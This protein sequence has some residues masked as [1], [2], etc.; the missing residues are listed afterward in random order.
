MSK[1]LVP[2]LLLLSLPFCSAP[3]QAQQKAGIAPAAAAASSAHQPKGTGIVVPSLKG[4]VFVPEAADV[5]KAGV[6]LTGVDVH[7]IAM[8]NNDDFR[9]LMA[10]YIG[11]PLTLDGL[12]ALT[13]LVVNYYRQQHHP[14]VDVLAPEQSLASGS[15]QIV[16]TEFR[17]GQVRATGNRWFSSSLVTAPMTLHHGDTINDQTVVNDLDAAN[18]NPFRRVNLV[19]QPSAQPG[20]T[21]IVLQTQDRL[22]ISLFS[23]FDNSGTPIT[24]RSRWN[25]GA[26]WGNALW[27]DQQLSWQMSTSDDFYTG[28]S[29]APG[30]PGGATFNGQNLTWS[31]PVFGRDSISLSGNYDRSLPN[32]GQ[33]FGL[34]GQSLGV[35]ARYNH[36][37]HRTGN[38]VQSLQA[39]YDFKS[40]N[41]NLAFGGTQVMR[42]NAEIDQFTTGYSA[43]LTDSR[44]STSLSTSLFFSP[45]NITP[46]NTA[47]AFQPATGQSGRAFASAH[48]TYWRS[49]VDRLTKLPEGAVWSLRVVGQTSSANLLYTEQL[50]GG[51]PEILRGYDPNSILGDQGVIVSNELR[52]PAFKKAG[53]VSLG[54]V[55]LLTFWDWAHLSSVHDVPDAIN[56][57][58]ASSV[59]AGIR[60]NIRTNMAVKF[61]Y[62][63]QLQHLTG[64]DS[65]DH[66]AN[67][68][69]LAS[70]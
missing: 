26:S 36:S 52:T 58:N 59:G 24:G 4:L 18:T 32:V 35:S 46:D 6:A 19:Y 38:L 37:L 60:Y 27:H 67:I 23:G 61:D 51:G 47:Q 1:A 70:Y 54:Q 13:H 44:G 31:M 12:N 2:S 14:M 39:G 3:L 29:A 56:H 34:V 69:L 62:G 10:A 48:Y 17:V 20:Y 66:L 49:D 53:E 40:T 41:N 68:S 9:G 55:Q 65:R 45:G 15:V 30:Q 25:L 11:R 64:T 21:D 43:N 57:L 33:D 42:N 5:Q 63:W 50:A 16:V 28:R 8:L 7:A 22:P